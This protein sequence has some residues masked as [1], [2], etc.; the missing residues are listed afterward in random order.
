ME[1]VLGAPGRGEVVVGACP[2]CRQPMTASGGTPVAWEIAAP[3]GLTV[4]FGADG[5][6]R[7]PDGGLAPDAAR[8]LLDR[9][10]PRDEETGGPTGW[11]LRAFQL[12]LVLMMLAPLAVWLFSVAFVSNFLAHTDAVLGP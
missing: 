1:V 6:I 11:R 7:G 4:T 3:N 5:T 9:A 12:A 2:A 10:L 8:R